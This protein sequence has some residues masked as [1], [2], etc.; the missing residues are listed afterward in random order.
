AVVILGTRSTR[1]HIDTRG[2]L[3][4]SGRATSAP[5]LDIAR[6][7]TLLPEPFSDQLHRKAHQ[8]D[9]RPE[10]PA[11][12]DDDPERALDHPANQLFRPLR[13]EREHLALHHRL[14]VEPL[15]Q[16]RYLGE[17]PAP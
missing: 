8:P 17:N 12:P 15:H 3:V 7:C 13:A 16:H 2:R 6:G 14:D 5:A 4:A 9:E 1:T 11:E 10:Q